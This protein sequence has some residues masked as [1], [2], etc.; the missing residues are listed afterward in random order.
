[1]TG[2]G[3]GTLLQ[4]SRRSRS[5]MT[6][7]FLVTPECT[8]NSREGLRRGWGVGVTVSLHV[9]LHSGWDV[10]SSYLRVILV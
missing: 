2:A 8:S 10:C 9:G 6:I 1:M 7:L 4:L 3:W 5:R